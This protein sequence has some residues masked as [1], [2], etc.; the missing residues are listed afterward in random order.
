MM[1]DLFNVGEQTKEPVYLKVLDKAA[2]VYRRFGI[3]YKQMRTILKM[4]MTMDSRREPPL[5]GYGSNANDSR[6]EK[7]HFFSSL[8]VYALIS[9]FL[10]FLFV[11]DNWVFQYTTYF[12]YV[13]VML[14]ST[15]LANFSNILLDV[16]DSELIGSKPVSQKTMGA[17][18]ATH[19][20]IYLVSFTG[21]VGLAVMAATFYF[22]G[23]IAGL[24][25]I[26]LTFLASMWSLGLTIVMYATVLKHFDGERLKNIIAYSQIGLS[27]FMVMGYYLMGQ[28]FEVIDP[29]TFLIE[30][31]LSL[32]HALIFPMWFVAPF[33]LVQEGFRTVYVVYTVFLIL[34]TAAIAVLYHYNND[35]I[36]SNLQK[37]NKSKAQP[38][39]RSMLERTAAKT[40]SW[41]SLER[42]YFHFT[43]QLTKNEREF[44]TRL[45]PSI[46]SAMVFPVVMFFSS[47][48]GD[49]PITEQNTMTF[50]YL[51]YFTMLAIP[52]IAVATQ[53]SVNYKGRWQ[54][55]LSPRHAKG[56][57]FRAV[58]KVMLVKIMLPMY[59]LIS[60]LI[61]ILTGPT[62]ILQ[63]VNGFLLMSAILY[64]E[65]K[66]SSQHLPFTRKYAASE[67]NQGCMSSL[68][69][70]VPVFIVSLVMILVQAFVP[71]A[72]WAVLI[73][74]VTYNLWWMNK[75]FNN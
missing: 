48:R 47:I 54:F 13:F 52:M 60:V 2:P 25:L 75:G 43:W 57:F 38:S 67:A 45:Y 24:L 37:M 71:F 6:K 70:F 3:D 66:R 16:K 44:K 36:D 72:E 12:S 26:L 62:Y 50:L 27:I 69:F 1:R 74:L 51:P 40:L 17:A 65:M 33:G 64:F 14:F 49:Q 11:Y 46:A 21:A 59:S 9:I 18:K 61:L 34:G 58:T 35:K 5:Q 30:M 15:M 73:G 63:L 23:V 68:I 31:N 7:N 8:W 39:N 41:D 28:I 4:K 29:E 55:E 53:F 10:L 56:P 32:G 20:A 42:A 22:N 19:V